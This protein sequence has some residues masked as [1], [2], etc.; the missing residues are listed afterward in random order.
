MNKRLFYALDIRDEDKLKI[1]I[2]RQP[3]IN[4]VRPVALD[5]FHITLCFMGS[6][7]PS[8]SHALNREIQQLLQS[9]PKL[10]NAQRQLTSDSIGLFRKPQVL[11]LDFKQFPENFR[12]IANAL[13]Q[14]SV[15]LGIHQENRPYRPHLTIARKA[16]MLPTVS[17]FSITMQVNAFSLYE[18]TSTKNGVSYIPI[19][20]W[21]L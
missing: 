5:N 19:Q 4:N 17:P 18:S 14:A 6:I 21:K 13:S 1:D 16:K 3:F 8:Q 9:L 2:L 15:N 7:S 12:K 20:S 11:Y 10:N